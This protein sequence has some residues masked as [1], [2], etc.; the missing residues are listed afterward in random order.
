MSLCPKCQKT[1][2]SDNLKLCPPCGSKK[3]SL[4][5]KIA[6]FVILA[7]ILF[8]VIYLK[9]TGY[10]PSEG[11]IEWLW[12]KNQFLTLAAILI[13]AIVLIFLVYVI[14]LKRNKR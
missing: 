12:H 1:Q 11:L 6:F 10:I 2:I 3:A 13:A 14:T 8:S 9:N 4:F 5:A 7:L